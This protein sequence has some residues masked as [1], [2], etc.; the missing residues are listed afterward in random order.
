MELFPKYCPE[1][2]QMIKI[3]FDEMISAIIFK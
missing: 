1:K 2:G 3:K